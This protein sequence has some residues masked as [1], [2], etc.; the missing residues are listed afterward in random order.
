MQ[1]LRITDP[2]RNEIWRPDIAVGSL[3][4]VGFAP[5]G[6]GTFGSILTFGMAFVMQATIADTQ[7][8]WWIAT[9]VCCVLSLISASSVLG[10]LRDQK[11]PSWF[12]MDEAAGVFLTYALIRPEG[13]LQLC[14]G[15][16]LFRVFD[17][18]KIWP[19]RNFEQVRGSL[20]I[21]LDDLVAGILAACLFFAGQ[22]V[23]A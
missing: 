12:V 9:V 18:A 3:L 5:F 14:A 6:R 21:L 15:L 7:M 4:F 10:R 17:I 22:A 8:L 16:V 2:P 23:F 11:D 1:F 20:G 19:V 13:F